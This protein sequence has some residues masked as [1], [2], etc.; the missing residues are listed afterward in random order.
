MPDVIEILDSPM[1]VVE[2]SVVSLSSRRRRR[3]QQ[4][5]EVI[6]LI[7][8]RSDEEQQGV[9][10]SVAA[11]HRTARL[12]AQP[13]VP[14]ASGRN[15]PTA[16]A[17]GVANRSRSRR[18]KRSRTSHDQYIEGR[19]DHATVPARLKEP[20]GQPAGIATTTPVGMRSPSTRVTN[21]TTGVASAAAATAATHKSDSDD[22]EDLFAVIEVEAP[23]EDAVLDVF[24]DAARNHVQDLLQRFGGNH[25]QVVSHLI[26]NPNYPKSK[27]VKQP[28]TRRP[29]GEAVVTVHRESTKRSW[30]YDFTLAAS[31]QPTSEYLDEATTCLYNE[32]PFLSKAGAKLLLKM[33]SHYALAHERLTAIL[34][35]TGDDIQQLSH[36][37]AVMASQSLRHDLLLQLQK[38]VPPCA[39]SL[40]MKS[41]KPSGADYISLLTDPILREE[42]E[43]VRQKLQNWVSAAVKKREREEKKDLVKQLGTGIECACCYDEYDIDDM[44][45]CRREGHLFCVDCLQQ[46]A[47]TKV[48]GEGNLGTDKK[49][50]EPALDLLCF[51]PEGCDSPFERN[52]LVK[53]LTSDTLL[54]YD[55][56]QA[57]LAIS[58]AGLCNLVTCP[59]CNFQADVTPSQKV[60]ECPCD[61]CRF[62]S[63]RECG[64]AAHAPLRYVAHSETQ[65]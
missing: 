13:I 50:K 3:K 65:R 37:Q 52:I 39:Q 63:C 60:F 54:K 27:T 31:F 34:R 40:V 22:E 35:G 42:V 46:Y 57:N 53:A 61:D 28:H 2:E 33:F 19:T 9:V 51:H 11:S 1:E 5:A 14:S 6:D 55:E 45:S 36:H 56:I 64:E 58:K 15:V 26:D 30:T 47:S 48:F 44:V 38:L 43:Y 24:P 59:K 49:T 41:K 29:L 21:A 17:P 10:T 8:E 25:E 62:V 7:D 20:P 23:L 18:E 32:F 16:A 12:S 4:F